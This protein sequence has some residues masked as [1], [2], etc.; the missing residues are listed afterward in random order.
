[1]KK[2][3]LKLQ[4]N[5]KVAKMA[6]SVERPSRSSGITQLIFVT[7]PKYKHH[8]FGKILI[9]V[10]WGFTLRSERSGHGSVG[11]GQRNA[12]IGR[13]QGAAVVA[14]I[15]D[16]RHLAPVTDINGILSFTSA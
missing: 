6:V 16:H 7:V 13:S 15:A 2:T 5:R 9:N 3:M 14:A 10:P 8:L 1:M 11:H 12:G 4:A